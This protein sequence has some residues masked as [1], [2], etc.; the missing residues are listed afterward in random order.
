[1]RILYVTGEAVMTL[2][3][4]DGIDGKAVR[5]R[6]VSLPPSEPDRASGATGQSEVG[7]RPPCRMGVRDM[8]I[9]RRCG[10]SGVS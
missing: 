2:G 7:R 6:P 8:G 10:A 1:M 9:S 4:G 5:P 3:G